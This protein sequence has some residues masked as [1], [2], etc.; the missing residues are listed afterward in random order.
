M[1][2]DTP[3]AVFSEKNQLLFGYFKQLFAQVTNPPIDPVR[4]ELVMSLMTFIGNPGNILTESP[5]NSRLI[6]LRHPIMTNEDLIRLKDLNLEGFRAKTVRIGFPQVGRACHTGNGAGPYL[7]RKRSGR[8]G[9]A[10][11]D[12]FERPGP[13]RRDTASIPSLWR[14]QPSTSIWW[15]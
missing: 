5:R 10:P 13:A 14:Y 3:L 7:R 4:E 6:K 15:P 9:R 1:G 12:R 2:A 11:T 8:Q